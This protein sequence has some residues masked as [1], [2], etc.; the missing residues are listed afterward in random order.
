MPLWI[1]KLKDLEAAGN[2]TGTY[3]YYAVIVKSMFFFEPPM[4]GSDYSFSSFISK[5]GSLS[6]HELKE[7]E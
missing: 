2:K 5:G 7:I 6:S 1:D 3:Y 4:E